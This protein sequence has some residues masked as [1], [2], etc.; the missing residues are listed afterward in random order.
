M[1][2]NVKVKRLSEDAI[3][4]SYAKQ[5]DAGADICASQDVIIKPGETVVIPTDIAI[6]IPPNYEVQIRPR[7]GITAKTK[8]RVQLGTV[9]SG[10][11]G[12]IGVII[13]NIAAPVVAVQDGDLVPFMAYPKTLDGEDY[14]RL[15]YPR[16]TYVIRRGDRIAQ[17]IINQHETALFSEV[18]ELSGSERG[19]GGFGSSGV[20]GE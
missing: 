19:N 9:D 11:R 15:W 16:G 13:D 10:Y 6:E 2:V 14:T 17:A 12:P 7:S 18:N 8:L 3:L 4:P 20:R 5:G 1:R